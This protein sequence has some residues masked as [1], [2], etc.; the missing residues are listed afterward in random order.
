MRRVLLLL[1]VAA[2]LVGGLLPTAAVRGAI[3]PEVTAAQYAPD[4]QECAFLG[5]VNRFRRQNGRKP[6]ALSV[7]LGAAAE[8]HSVDMA[9]NDY[10]SHDL[11]NGVSWSKNIRKHGYRGNPIGENIAA[12]MESAQAAFATWKDSPPHRKNMLGRDYQAIG[13]GRAFGRDT[14]YGWYWTTTFGG[15]IEQQVGCG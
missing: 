15:P 9:R 8:H 14:D 1:L 6:L 13:I 12:G 4:E 3:R 7:S 11:H 10:F 5:L 2:L